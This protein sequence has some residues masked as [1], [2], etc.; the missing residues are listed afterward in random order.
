MHKLN[1][2]GKQNSSYERLRGINRNV[3]ILLSRIESLKR[4][5]D[6]WKLGAAVANCCSL[7]SY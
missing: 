6:Q 5:I 1:I 3:K 7:T 4:S 2:P